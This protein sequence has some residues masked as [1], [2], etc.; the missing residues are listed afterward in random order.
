MV[1]TEMTPLKYIGTN[2]DDSVTWKC[3][4]CGEFL[5]ARSEVPP[6]HTCLTGSLKTNKTLTELEALT[7]FKLV[8]SKSDDSHYTGFS[9]QPIDLI[10]S[11]KLPFLEGEV[12][13]VMCRWKK[14][15]GI[16]DLKK[17]LG[18]VQLLIDLEGTSE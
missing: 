4:K 5:R 18:Y 1:N 8:G 2:F 11:A 17:A 14:K 9:I 13:A 6:L 7:K 10:V 12:V 3:T 15:G 16:K